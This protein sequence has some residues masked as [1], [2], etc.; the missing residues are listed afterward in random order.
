LRFVIWVVIQRGLRGSTYPV[1]GT[2]GPFRDAC[3]QS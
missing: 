1:L 3:D 2:H